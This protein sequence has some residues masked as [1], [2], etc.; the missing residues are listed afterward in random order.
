MQEH[1]NTHHRTTHAERSPSSNI[2]TWPFKRRNHDLLL[3]KIHFIRFSELSCKCFRSYLS[4]RS[5]LI[6]VDDAR[7]G[8]TDV[9]FGVPKGSILAP[10]LFSILVSDVAS[11]ISIHSYANNTQ[12]R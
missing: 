1:T 9:L 11:V 4:G 10:I 8:S 2:W 6:D 5:Q 12:H 7:S 3:A